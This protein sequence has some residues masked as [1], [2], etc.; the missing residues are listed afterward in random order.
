MFLNMKCTLRLIAQTFAFLLTLSLISP[1]DSQSYFDL[2]EGEKAPYSSSSKSEDSKTEKVD[3]KDG[4]EEIAL[5]ELIL[6]KPHGFI[7][8]LPADSISLSSHS[9]PPFQRPPRV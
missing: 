7:F 9:V 6:V 3:S 5:I 4:K 8:Y 1:I 2:N